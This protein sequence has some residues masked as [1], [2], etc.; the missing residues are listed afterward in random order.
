MCKMIYMQGFGEA[1]FVITKDMKQLKCP[2][3]ENIHTMDTM[4]L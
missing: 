4:Q 1:L 2:S 3:I